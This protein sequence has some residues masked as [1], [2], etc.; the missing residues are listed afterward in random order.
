LEVVEVTATVPDQVPAELI[1]GDTW[2]WTRTLSD[3]PAGTWTLVY[4]FE[5]K[6]ATFSATASASG[7]IHSVSIAAATTAGY[8]SGRYRWRARASSGGNSY[9]VESGFADVVFD[10]AASGKRDVRSHARRV[11]E[12]IE[13]TIEGRASNDQLAMTINGRSISRTPLA[14]L[15]VARDKYKWEVAAEDS[16]ERVAAGLGSKKRVFVRFG[17]A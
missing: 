17:R 5:N 15:L 9:T 14:E 4:Y 1:A 13:A 11:L 6:D 2:A 8:A 7:T 16:A 10:P 12:A 3:Y